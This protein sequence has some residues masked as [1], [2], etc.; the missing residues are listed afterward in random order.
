M[1]TLDLVLCKAVST[2]VFPERGWIG[3]VFA[4]K[5]GPRRLEALY[6]R[7]ELYRKVGEIM[8]QNGDNAVREAVQKF[9]V[10][11]TYQLMFASAKDAYDGSHAKKLIESHLNG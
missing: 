6:T 5:D 7:P 4:T 8:L 9:K 1:K 10:P 3:I 11:E 2:E